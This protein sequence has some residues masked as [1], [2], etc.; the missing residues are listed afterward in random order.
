MDSTA[1]DPPPQCW[2]GTR[3]RINGKLI[4]WLDDFAREWDML[5]LFGPA[6]TGKSAC[7][8]KGRLGAAFF[9]SRPNGRDNSKTVIPSLVYQ[10]CVYCPAYKLVVGK[11]LADH[12]HLVTKAI[13]VQFKKLLLE[14]LLQ[15]Q[16]S[17]DESVRKPFLL[18]LDGLDECAGGRA[19]SEFINLIAEHVRTRPGFPILWLLCSR[20]EPH[21]K[22]M[23][24]RIPE[25]GREELFLDEESREDVEHFLRERFAKIRDDN[26]ESMSS[27]WPSV[28]QFIIIS[29]F[30]HGHFQVAN[31]SIDYVAA[32]RNPVAQLNRLVSFITRKVERLRWPSDNPLAAMDLLYL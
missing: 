27:N 19:Q 24:M 10:F 11:T 7:F 28:E 32:L 20:P 26:P 9:F 23:F 2:P 16:A 25:C 13:S 5:W 12:P 17:D 31:G 21:L 3:V 30:C 14:P 4:S 8:E 6:G 29:Q 18:L 1:R 22:H 15:L